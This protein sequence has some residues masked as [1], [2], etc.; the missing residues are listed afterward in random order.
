MF[1]FKS[2]EEPRPIKPTEKHRDKL[3]GT[4]EGDSRAPLQLPTTGFKSNGAAIWEGFGHYFFK[5]SCYPF[6]SSLLLGLPLSC[7]SERIFLID[8]YLSS[9]RLLSA[10]FCCWKLSSEDFIS[11]ILLAALEFSFVPLLY[12]FY[13]FD[14]LFVETFL[15]SFSLF[16]FS[17][18][19]LSL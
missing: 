9:L 10:Q 5:N 18:L 1:K 11:I 6:S 19:P 7:S 8:L 17:W 14:I 12:N 16:L 4:A 15:S 3:V 2:I 13:H